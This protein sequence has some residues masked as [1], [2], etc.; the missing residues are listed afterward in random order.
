MMQQQI[1]I[2]PRAEPRQA[3][4]LTPPI[5]AEPLPAEPLA[6]RT[7]DAYLVRITTAGYEPVVVDVTSPDMRVI[8]SP[9]RQD[10]CALLVPNL[11]AAHPHLGQGRIQAEYARLGIL[12]SAQT[13]EQRTSSPFLMPDT[14]STESVAAKPKH[15]TRPLRHADTQDR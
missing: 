15:Y 2:D 9:S 8:G 3:P 14:S 6:T 5:A 13:P 7:L 1:N 4:W 11:A 12:P 10:H